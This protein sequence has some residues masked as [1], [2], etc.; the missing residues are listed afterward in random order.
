MDFTKPKMSEYLAPEVPQSEI[1][2]KWEWGF[3]VT[4]V[5]KNIICS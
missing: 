5:Q 2:A 1:K 4:L 3:T